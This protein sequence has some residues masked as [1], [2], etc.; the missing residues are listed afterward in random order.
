[1]R[2]AVDWP[3]TEPIPQSMEEALTLGWRVDGS[4]EGRM[5]DDELFETGTMDLIKDLSMLQLYLKIPFHAVLTYGKPQ[6][7]SAF[8][9]VPENPLLS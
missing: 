7:A 8:V 2:T 4:A 9:R 6:N 3:E 1:M 5:S